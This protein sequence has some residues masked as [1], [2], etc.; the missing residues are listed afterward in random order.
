MKTYAHIAGRLF[1]RPLLMHPPVMRNFATVLGRR[2]SGNDSLIVAEADIIRQAKKPK[3]GDAPFA[4][5]GC[6]RVRDICEQYG[7]VA[8]IHICGAIDKALSDFE[9]ECF[10]CCDLHD[11]DEAIELAKND[12]MITKVVFHFDTPGGSTCGV[13]ETTDRI[14][15]L[16]QV[17]EV[18]GYTDT[19]CC[20]AGMWL[21]SACDHIAVTPSSWVG[22]IGVYMT[23][24]DAAKYYEMEGLRVE[25]VSAGKFKTMCADWKPATEDERVLL[26]GQINGT[27]NNFK[28]AITAQR[29]VPEEAM[30]GQWYDGAEA[31]GYKVVDEVTMLCLDEYVSSLLLS[32]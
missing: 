7:N 22:S 14:R 17:K 6:E 2:I 19:L 5:A 18:H 23:W 11:V 10:E 21:A 4:E 12:P 28:A 30:Q 1:N 3:C 24:W 31:V 29:A 13:V 16:A 8:I 20:S 9:V 32:H 26:Q 27:W 15:R 25:C